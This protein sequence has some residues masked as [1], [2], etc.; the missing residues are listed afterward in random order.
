ME[1]EAKEER[2]V[3]KAYALQKQFPLGFMNVRFNQIEKMVEL[4]DEYPI[5]QKKK[6]YE[7]IYAF[8]K[9]DFD[10][11]KFFSYS[12]W[13][14]RTRSNCFNE[15]YTYFKYLKDVFSKTK[16]KNQYGSLYKMNSV[17][18][19]IYDYLLLYREQK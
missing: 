7:H 17:V 18:C 8:L 11:F 6:A 3:K 19:D 14:L 15:H 4:Y 10:R 12:N 1:F 2:L 9:L 5:T 13:G 16:A